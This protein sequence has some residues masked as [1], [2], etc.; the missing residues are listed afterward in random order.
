MIRMNKYQYHLELIPYNFHSDFRA[1]SERIVTRRHS[2]SRYSH[3]FPPHTNKA[4]MRTRFAKKHSPNIYIGICLS[5]RVPTQSAIRER[6]KRGRK[7]ATADCIFYTRLR[8]YLYPVDEGERK[9]PIRKHRARS[10][11][12]RRQRLYCSSSRE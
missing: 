6:S 2:T 10:K 12:R 11:T 7:K 4:H 8:I 1:F 3:D 5:T 9:T